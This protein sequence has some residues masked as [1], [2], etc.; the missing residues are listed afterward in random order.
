[1]QAAGA[2]IGVAAVSSG[3]VL[4]SYRHADLDGVAGSKGVGSSVGMEVGAGCR[5]STA[6]NADR[7]KPST[8]TANEGQMHRTT[9]RA[10]ATR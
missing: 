9:A 10:T 8:A 4:W 3:D 2:K 1:M 7:L 6:A 5:A